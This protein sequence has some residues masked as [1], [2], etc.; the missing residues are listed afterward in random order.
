MKILYCNKYNHRIR[1]HRIL[2]VSKR[3]SSCAPWGTRWAVF[4]WPILAASPLGTITIFVPHIDFKQAER[5][6]QKVRQGR[7]R[8]IHTRPGVKSAQCCRIPSRH[9]PCAEYLSPSS[10]SILWELKT[11]RYPGSVSPERLQGALRQ[12]QL[13]RHGEACEACKGGVFWHALQEKCYPGWSARVALVAEAYVHK[14]LGTYRKCVDCFSR[15]ANSC[16]I[17]SSNRGGIRK[18]SRCCPI[19]SRVKTVAVRSAENPSLLYF[20]RLSPGKR[21]GDLLH[22]MQRLPGLRLIIAGG[23]A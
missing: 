1:W 11:A 7:G 9:G 3:W 19:S 6:A 21:H 22:A 8:S 16:A 4:Q 2:P 10:P 15:P 14:W 20:G 17:N 23:R 18:S 13:S 12:L 5:M